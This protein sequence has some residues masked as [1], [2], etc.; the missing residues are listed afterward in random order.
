VVRHR[1]EI[2]RPLDAGLHRLRAEG[3]GQHDLLALRI[4]IGGGGIV[5]LARD[6][7]VEGEARM[8]VEIAEHRAAQGILIRAGLALLGPLEARDRRGD[9]GGAGERRGPGRRRDRRRL[10]ASRERLRGAGEQGGDDGEAAEARRAGEE[11]GEEPGKE[12]G[13]GEDDGSGI[14]FRHGR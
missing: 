9:R 10:R 5:A 12:R 1:R 2:E 3:V 14:R 11:R 7:G 13:E 8:D 4:A 6:V